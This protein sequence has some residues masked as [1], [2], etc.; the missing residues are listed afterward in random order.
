M[1]GIGIE[2]IGLESVTI[3]LRSMPDRV[4]QALERAVETEAL[5][6]VR[7]VKED[8]LSG[9]VLGQRTHRLR[10]SVHM[11]ALE[12]DA[13]TVEAAV[14][15]NLKDAKYAAFWEYGFTG[16]EQVREHT[17]K[18]TQAFGRPIDERTILVRAHARHVDQPPRSYLRSTLGEEADGIRARLRAAVDRAAAGGAA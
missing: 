1:S 16:I 17:R 7:I 11:L 15:V 6:L 13:D 14:G 8:K 2:Q 10:D 9:Q 3:Q 18:I 4:R 5:N 12:S